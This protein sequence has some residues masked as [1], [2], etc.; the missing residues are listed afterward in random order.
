MY[1]IVKLTSNIRF[2]DSKG[3]C[4]LDGEITIMNTI[5]NTYMTFDNIKPYAPKG[6]KKALKEILASNNMEKFSFMKPYAIIN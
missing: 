6:K 3:I 4:S 5:D 1:K 2:K